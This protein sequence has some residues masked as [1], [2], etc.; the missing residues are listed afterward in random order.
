[1][2]TRYERAQGVFADPNVFAPFLVAPA[3][4]LIYG[5]MNR[6]V[7]MLPVRMLCL[8]IILAGL[9]LAF[10]RGAWGM[11]A[12]AVCLFY[13]LILV[14]ERHP[15]KRIKFVLFGVFGIATMI[16][17]LIAALQIDVV[18]SIFQQRAELVQEYDGARLGRFARHLIGFELAL[19][20]PLGLGPPGI[21]I[22]LR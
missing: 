10:S 15:M 5:I 19:S 17:A 3:L 22:Y 6:S 8:G 16:L 1:M 7:T 13:F 2:F 14:C 9:F 11:F 18:Y 12:A 4:Y 20:T 21:R